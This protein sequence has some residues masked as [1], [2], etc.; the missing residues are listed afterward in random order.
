METRSQNNYGE[1][2]TGQGKGHE[3]ERMIY[4]LC[5]DDL[6]FTLLSLGYFHCEEHGFLE[7]SSLQYNN[8]F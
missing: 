4:D 6:C 2:M 1:A 8:V 7:T 5:K 3:G